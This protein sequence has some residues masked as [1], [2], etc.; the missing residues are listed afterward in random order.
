MSAGDLAVLAWCDLGAILRTRPVVLDQLESKRRFGLGWAAA[1]CA[2]TPFDGIVPN[3]WGSV[4]EVRQVPVEG[5]SVVVAAGGGMPAFHLHLTRMLDAAGRL[6]DACPRNFCEDAL[7]A[8]A[9]ASGLTLCSAFEHEFTVTEAPFRLGAV[10]SVESLRLAANFAHDVTF[11]MRALEL[12]CFEP[13]FGKGQF[14]ISCAPQ[15]GVCGADRAILSRE[16]V[17]EIARRHSVRLTFSPKPTPD[18]AGNGMHV[19]FSFRD[20]SGWP[21]TYDAHSPGKVTPLVASFIGG[22]MRHIGALTAVCAPAPVSY[23][24]LGPGHWSC[25]YAAFGV[26]NR[27]A[28]LRVCPSPDTAPDA[29]AAATNIELRIPDGTANP[30]LVIGMLA[31]AGLAGIRA[32]LPLPPI[33]ERDPA[34]M[35]DA[36]RTAADVTPLP[37]TL[38]AALAAFEADPIA[39]EWM[40]V[41]LRDT[42]MAIKRMEI[43]RFADADPR[44]IAAAYR[45][46]Y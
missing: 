30:Y 23:L 45:D 37:G 46:L 14:E 20:R 10:Y 39:W 5:A 25:G 4:D 12:E 28:A 3:P 15:P 18:G 40:P 16:V 29:A 22:V 21:A 8:L 2:M 42:F 17:R 34:E 26:Q 35:T 1:G 24:R 33:V 19:H 7:A 27:E 36:E 32:G 31:L 9:A 11:A 41:R 38:S 43:D 44:A 13:E 6:S